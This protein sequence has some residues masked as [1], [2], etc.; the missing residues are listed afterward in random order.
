MLP[1]PCLAL[2]LKGFS[3]T[4]RLLSFDED[5]NLAWTKFG[6]EKVLPYAILSYIWRAEEVSFVDLVDDSGKSKAGYRKIVF[7]SEEAARDNLRYFWVDTCCIGKRNNNELTKAINSMFRWYRSTVEC[8]VYLSDV[9]TPVSNVDAQL[10]Q[11]AW[12][13]DFRKSRWFTRGWTLQELLASAS[14]TFYSSQQERLGGKKSLSGVIHEVTGIPMPALDG[15]A[16][17]AFSAAEQMAW[18]A[19]RQ[20]T[21]EEDNACCLLGIFDVFM[22]LIYG[23]GRDSALQ[24]LQREVDGIPTTG[25]MFTT[26]LISKPH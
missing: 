8:Y 17:E 3:S 19:K 20:T 14:V 12:E 22:P 5:D 6:Q 13:T 7:C 18:S 25:T 23:E 15:H 1:L 4:M 26:T 10:C 2:Y 11:S 9:P 16:L 21:E 24:R